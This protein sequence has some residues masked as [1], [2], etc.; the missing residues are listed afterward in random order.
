MNQIPLKWIT[1]TSCPEQR[2]LF[3]GAVEIIAD[4]LPDSR[5]AHHSTG[6]LCLHLCLSQL[7]IPVKHA[8][9]QSVV[10]LNHLFFFDCCSKNFCLCP[11]HFLSDLIGF[12]IQSVH[13]LL[14]SCI[15]DKTKIQQH[16]Q[17]QNRPDGFCKSLWTG[18]ANYICELSY[19]L[20]SE[21]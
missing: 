14:N 12:T 21:E 8:K 6:A 19:M 10:A 13:R 4:V 15:V 11:R 16:R 20:N 1:E 3:P 18:N 5:W 2:V 9:W 7:V 17:T